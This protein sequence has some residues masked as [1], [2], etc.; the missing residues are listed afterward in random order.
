[1]SDKEFRRE[2]NRVF[3][4]VSGDPSPA[5]RDRVRS[6]VAQAPEHR[7]P[8]W[9]AAVAATLIAVFIVGVLVVGSSLSRRPR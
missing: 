3:D 2:L 9:L 1:M 6:S 4:E 5:L 7:G 8:Y